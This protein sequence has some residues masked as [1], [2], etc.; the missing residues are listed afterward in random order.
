[1]YS[2]IAK[3]HKPTLKPKLGKECCLPQRTTKT[4]DNQTVEKEQRIQPKMK[5]G[6]FIRENKS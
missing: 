4:T 6:K 1:M 5:Q 2:S 3:P